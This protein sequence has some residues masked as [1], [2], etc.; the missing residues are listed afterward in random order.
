MI[1]VVG[2]AFL[3]AI[4]ASF[5]TGGNKAVILI[6]FFG[7]LALTIFPLITGQSTL[8]CPSCRKRVKL[9]AT[10]CHH[11]GRTVGASS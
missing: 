1:R 5:I 6:A 7:T 10:A 8:R 9:G 2:L 11:C 4:V 3:V